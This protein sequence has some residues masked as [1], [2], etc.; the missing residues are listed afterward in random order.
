MVLG[1]KFDDASIDEPNEDLVYKRSSKRPERESGDL[2][3]QADEVMRDIESQA[4][5]ATAS[6]VL[7]ASPNAEELDPAD[8]HPYDID[9]ELDAIDENL[10]SNEAV[11]ELAEEIPVSENSLGEFARKEA[12]EAEARAQALRRRR[13]LRNILIVVIIILLLIAAVIGVFVWRN[14]M[15]PDIKSADTDALVTSKAGVD[16]TEFSTIDANTVPKLTGLF[17]K[18]VSQAKKELG[19][20]LKL[21]GS[22]EK[23]T[24]GRVS[25]LKRL[26]NAL[27]FDN[28]GQTLASMAFGLN[29]K[30]KIV[31]VY[32]SF[33]LD[34]LGVADADFSTLAH[35]RTVAESLL[36]GVGVSSETVQSAKL[37]LDEGEAVQDSGKGEEKVAFSGATGQTA[38]PTKWE[39]TESYVLSSEDN[40]TTRKALIELY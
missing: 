29:K 28:E 15:S 17:G 14:S 32:C 8:I 18:T 31:Y 11:D 39:L 23:A 3:E 12:E 26:Q 7:K 1:D 27:Y 4:S 16:S 10:A 34:V 30:G 20:N 37:S 40:S 25:S 9:D 21:T 38:A 22:A 2:D 24:D 5:Q 35:S 19:A 6:F 33:D 36:T 13:H